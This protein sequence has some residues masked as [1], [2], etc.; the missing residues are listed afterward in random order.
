MDVEGPAWL[1]HLL[2]GWLWLQG[3]IRWPAQPIPSLCVPQARGKPDAWR[4]GSC[5]EMLP[6]Q[7]PGFCSK[8]EGRE[9]VP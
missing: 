2:W 8:G 4:K 5:T 1:G 6:H 9:F 7:H 3:S